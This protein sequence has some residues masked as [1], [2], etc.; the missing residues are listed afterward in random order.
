VELGQPVALDSESVA[1]L[2]QLDHLRIARFSGAAKILIGTESETDRA[3]ER[4]GG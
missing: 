3:R 4:T 2:G 1:H